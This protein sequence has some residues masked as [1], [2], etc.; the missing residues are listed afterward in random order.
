MRGSVRS[1]T[2]VC[3]NTYD[4]R[5]IL[6]HARQTGSQQRAPAGCWMHASPL[7]YVIY[8][9]VKGSVKISVAATRMR[10]VS[11]V[12]CICSLSRMENDRDD[13]LATFAQLDAK[14]NYKVMRNSAAETEPRQKRMIKRDV[15]HTSLWEHTYGTYN[16]SL[17]RTNV[18]RDYIFDYK[19]VSLF[20]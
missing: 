3:G 7:G 15:C 17:L 8:R 18:S 12:S 9:P 20:P 14:S 5:R 19:S 1:R 2:V 6:W 11:A 13:S 16:G 10:V 4:R